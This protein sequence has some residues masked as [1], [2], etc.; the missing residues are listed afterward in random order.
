MWYLFAGA[1]SSAV[2]KH[3]EVQGYALTELA[4]RHADQ[5]P[6]SL[7]SNQETVAAD[8]SGQVGGVT[9]IPGQAVQ[10]PSHSQFRGGVTGS[11]L[12]EHQRVK[13]YNE[14][15]NAILETRMVDGLSVL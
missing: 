8:I 4:M 2:V 9:G 15:Q 14:S 11:S 3:L 7:Q 1:G 5:S 12:P 6:P 10:A 13:A